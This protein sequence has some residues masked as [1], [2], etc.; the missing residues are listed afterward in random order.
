MSLA[1]ALLKKGHEKEKPGDC[2]ALAGFGPDSLRS[3]EPNFF[4]LG[5]KSYGRRSDFLLRAGREQVR[6]V[7]KIIEESPQLDLYARSAT[8]GAWHES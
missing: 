4:I 5:H 8:A 3:P 1:A 2:L 6:D 7:F